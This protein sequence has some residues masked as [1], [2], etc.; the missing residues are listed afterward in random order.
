MSFL[1]LGATLYMPA[2]RKDITAIANGLII[3]NLRSVV[4]CTED[5]ISEQNLPEALSNLNLSLNQFHQADLYRFIRPRNPQVLQR[6]LEIPSIGN[7]DGFVLPK[8]T[9]NNLDTYFR[10]LERHE[11]YKIMITLETEDVF[12]PSELFRMRDALARTQY[13]DRIM[14]IRIGGLDLLNVLGIRRACN[15]TIYDTPIGYCICQLVTAFKPLGFNLSAPAYECFENYETLQQ[16]VEID[17]LNGLF[18]KTAIHPGQIDIIQS[19]YRVIDE[20][21]EMAKAILDPSFP[22]VFR[23]HSTMC[24]KATHWNW[25]HG[26]IERAKIY[27][28]IKDRSDEQIRIVSKSQKDE[29]AIVNRTLFESLQEG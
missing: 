20:D 9:V 8:V 6:I 27:G 12:N 7:I 19:A 10:I 16:E 11:Q 17:L 28:T 14:T 24:E 23:M 2:T 1:K 18:G 21:F 4:F 26:I 3:K 22:A 5:A 13:K 29:P 25:A 15:R